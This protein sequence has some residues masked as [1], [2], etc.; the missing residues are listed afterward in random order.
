MFIT[1]NWSTPRIPNI[2]D[3]Q[4]FAIYVLTS[5]RNGTENPLLGT[6]VRPGDHSYNTPPSSNKTGDFGGYNVA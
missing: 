1:R 4:I 2:D 3:P 6:S 5:L